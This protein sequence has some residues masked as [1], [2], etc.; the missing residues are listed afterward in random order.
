MTILMNIVIVEIGWPI[1]SVSRIYNIF[2]VERAPEFDV[3]MSRLFA[4]GIVR[5]TFESHSYMRLVATAMRSS[6]MNIGPDNHIL[7]ALPG[8]E[9]ELEDGASYVITTTS[10]PAGAAASFA[11]C[12]S[13]PRRASEGLLV[14][15]ITLTSSGRSRTIC[16]GESGVTSW[17]GIPISSFVYTD[18]R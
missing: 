8:W 9:E 16:S 12:S 13:R 6:G 7:S 2:I 3:D 11:I 14:L 18:G 10:N 5:R 1:S 17:G 15:H 4:P